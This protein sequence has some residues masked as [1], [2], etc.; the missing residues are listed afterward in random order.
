MTSILLNFLDVFFTRPIALAIVG[1][2]SKFCN[3]V[4]ATSLLS[5]SIILRIFVPCR[6]T[7]TNRPSP[8]LI[9]PLH[10]A[11]L[12]TGLSRQGQMDQRRAHPL[13]PALQHSRVGASA[14]RISNQHATSLSSFPQNHLSAQFY[15]FP[16]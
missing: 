14:R 13:E 7:S 9:E 5:S 8:C 12:L 15:P 2:C 16:H 3:R 10:P 6:S 1:L 11:T 4:S